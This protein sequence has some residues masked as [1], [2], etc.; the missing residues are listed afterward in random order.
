M[1]TVRT[2]D[3]WR[4]VVA[5]ALFAGAVGIVARRPLALLSAVVAVAFAIYPR[6]SPTPPVALDLERAVEETA[7]PGDA[8][9]VTVTLR[10]VG[11][12]T[13]PD[14]RIVDGVPPMLSVSSG[15][16]RHAAVLRPGAAT[17]FSYEV[18]AAAGRH[19]FD[20]ATVLVRDASGA[21]EVET[22]VGTETEI[23]CTEAVPD[24]PL[25]RQTDARVGPV[26]TDDGGSGVEFYRTREYRPGDPMSR[27]DWNR[28]ARTGELTTVDFR[29]ER[30]AS[31]VVCL[32]ARRVAYRARDDEPHAVAYGAAAAESLCSALLGTRQRVGLAAVGREFCWRSPGT[33]SDH[34]ARVR[35][36]LAAH[37][38]LS[39]IPPGE[40]GTAPSANSPTDAR[41]DGS[42]RADGGTLRDAERTSPERTTARSERDEDQ[43]NSDAGADPDAAAQVTE[44]RKRLAAD[45]QVVWVSPLVDEF[46]VRTALE[47]EAS[48]TAVTVVSPDPTDDATV[49]GRLARVERENRIVA[50]RRSGVSVV[51][52]DPDD[53]LST[54]VAVAERRRSA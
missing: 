39:A 48:G 13:L 12:R 10:N 9:E 36:M 41:A 16:A 49:G 21:T 18:A 4:G 11:D 28:L 52:W 31:V 2:T 37:P 30:A 34:A 3:R 45:A 24:A 7:S 42:A 50:L 51:D 40:D 32:D 25:R 14:V 6:V 27:V 35:E 29:E 44:L 54:A 22:T 33:G 1:T 5:L 19:Q 15:N 23:D 53:P 8:V 38:T 26:A 17:T 20:P 46:A 47:L 43:R